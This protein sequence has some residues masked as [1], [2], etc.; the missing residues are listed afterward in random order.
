[1][2]LGLCDIPTKKKIIELS[3]KIPEVDIT[4]LETMLIFFNKANKMHHAIYDKL[5][6]KGLSK[7]KFS[8]LMNIYGEGENGIYP[9]ELADKTE[10]SRA[11][12]TGFLARLE[13]D[14]MIRRRGD[15]HD[16]RMSNVSLTPKGIAMMEENLPTH[17][18]R[19]SRLMRNLSESERALLVS[20][21]GKILTTE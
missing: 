8:I 12:V 4:A 2:E 3:S 19:V 11:T 6:E 10:V 17:F 14:D 13:R 9:S 1:M 20:L 7:G 15:Q 18:I 5:E 16:G 21:L